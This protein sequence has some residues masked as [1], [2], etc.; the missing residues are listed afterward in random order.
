MEQSLV[1]EG[2]SLL[3]YVFLPKETTEVELTYI[4]RINKVALGF[5]AAHIPLFVL[6]AYLSNT[7]VTQA[8]VFGSMLFLGPLVATLTL[9]N[10]RTLSLVFGFTSMCL[11]ALLVHL[12]QGPMQIEMHFHFFASL[13]LL[14]V[15]GNPLIIWVAAITVAAHHGLF[16]MYL[17]DSVFNY[18]ASF[19]VVGVHAA[20]VV[21]ESVAASFIARNFFDNV[22]GLEK[23]IQERTVELES[24]NS[25]MSLILDNTVQGFLMVDESGDLLGKQ[26]LVIRDWFGPAQE[27]E[28]IWNYLGK[29]SKD[30]GELTEMGFEDIGDGVMPTEF[31]LKSLPKLMSTADDSTFEVQYKS[32]PYEEKKDVFLVVISNITEKLAHEKEVKAQ[33]EIIDIFENINRDRNG[34]IEYIAES[35]EIINSLNER[36]HMMG[37]AEVARKVHTLKGNSFVFKVVSLGDVCHEIE[38][39][40]SEHS[41]TI[42]SEDLE[43]I[44][45][46]WSDLNLR[47]DKFLDENNDHIEIEQHELTNLIKMVKDNVSNQKI[48]SVLTSWKHEPL[49]KRLNRISLQAQKLAERLNKD[50]MQVECKDNDLRFP[51]EEWTG[52]WSVLSHVI[53]NSIDHGIEDLEERLAKGKKGTG[54]L[55]LETKFDGE[56]LVVLV[57]DDGRGINVQQLREV[58]QRKGFRFNNDEQDLNL[59]FEDGVSTKTEVSDVSGR[60]VGLAAVK[61]Y[62]HDQGVKIH[63]ESKEGEGTTFE[64]RVPLN[65][66]KV[67]VAA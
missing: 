58:A 41:G 18:D 46:S 33:L 24:R 65:R 43:M 10:P 7:S 36:H 6:V 29:K 16:W 66:V 23:I 54:L 52:F 55:T 13:A 57:S 44:N 49:K 14:T 53:R 20:F 47:L 2:H 15:W 9:E 42:S 19:W 30:F 64:F 5:C 28:K 67:S 37:S 32:I 45:K 60:G 8:L 27:G 34:F 3:K 31:C 22:I 62:C 38:N 12:G 48:S 61:S 17:P 25:E 56:D 4:K 21:V 39:N 40:M 26:S 11:G 59:I 35:K 1:Q 51:S 63:L 50:G